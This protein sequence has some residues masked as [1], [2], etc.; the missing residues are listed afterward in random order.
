MFLHIQSIADVSAKFHLTVTDIV[1]WSKVV[2]CF[3]LVPP[4]SPSHQL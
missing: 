3:S 2:D 4:S 1:V